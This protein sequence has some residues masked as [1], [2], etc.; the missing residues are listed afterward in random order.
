MLVTLRPFLSL[1]S[2]SSACPDTAR[3]S[4]NGGELTLTSSLTSDTGQYVCEAYSS[5]GTVRSRT[6]LVEV[7]GEWVEVISEW[8]EVVGEWVEV[9]GEWVEVVGEWVEVVGE[10]VAVRAVD[11]YVRRTMPLLKFM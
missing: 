1:L 3:F 6:I 5:A 10:W 9:V 2:F 11:K 7:I 8:V 4:L